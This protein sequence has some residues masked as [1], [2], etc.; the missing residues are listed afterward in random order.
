MQDSNQHKQTRL[1]RISETTDALNELI[2]AFTRVTN[3]TGISLK[4]EEK[5]KKSREISKSK[6][7]K[8]RTSTSH[9]EKKG[10]PRGKLQRGAQTSAEVSWAAH[11]ADW[12]RT[13]Q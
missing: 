12:N 1:R 7:E 3:Q 2:A 13:R 4:K 10:R 5:E 11:K 8:E 6:H 9:E